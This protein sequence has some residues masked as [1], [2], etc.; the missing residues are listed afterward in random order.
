MGKSP[1][2]VYE[3]KGGAEHYHGH[4]FNTRNETREKKKREERERTWVRES[5]REVVGDGGGKKKRRGEKKVMNRFSE[6]LGRD[7]R[8]LKR[9]KKGGKEGAS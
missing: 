8:G 5:G 3:E 6:F 2:C 1:A 4:L 7:E 9:K